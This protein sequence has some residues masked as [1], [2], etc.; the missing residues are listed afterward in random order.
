MS[1][2]NAVW[3]IIA[4]WENE[5]Q[6]MKN[7]VAKTANKAAK[8]QLQ[9]SGYRNEPVRANPPSQEATVLPTRNEADVGCCFP[10]CDC[11]LICQ[12]RMEPEPEPTWLSREQIKQEIRELDSLELESTEMQDFVYH[13]INELLDMLDSTE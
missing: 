12:R 7:S 6:A 4:Q 2:P 5:R 13:R 11:Q 10:D 3:A 1:E 9:N 8:L